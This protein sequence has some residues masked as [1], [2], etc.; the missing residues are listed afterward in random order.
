MAKNRSNTKRNRKHAT[1]NPEMHQAFMELR[2]SSATSRHVPGHRK[3]SKSANQSKA[4]SNSL[5]GN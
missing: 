3:G 2:R 1:A 4:I 5:A